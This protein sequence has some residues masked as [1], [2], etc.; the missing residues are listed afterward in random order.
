MQVCNMVAAARESLRPPISVLRVVC[1]ASRDVALHLEVFFF[2]FATLDLER[3]SRLLY[4]AKRR[5]CTWIQ[6]NFFAPSMS[7]A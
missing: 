1:R 4:Q 6:E 2:F 3:M 5:A 7:Y